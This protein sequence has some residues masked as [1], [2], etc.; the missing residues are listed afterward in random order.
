MAGWARLHL[1]PTIAPPR[2][3]QGHFRPLTHVDL[4][5]AA[6]SAH[7]LWMLTSMWE[8]FDAA[9]EWPT[10]Q[11]VGARFWREDRPEPRDV[12]LELAEDGFVSPRVQRDRLFELRDDTRASITLDGLM[13]VT[14]A[15]PDLAQFVSA[16]RYLGERAARFRP[17]TSTTLESLTIASDEIRLALPPSPT[18]ADLRR[19]AAFI[20]DY[21]P[22]LWTGFSGPDLAGQWTVTVAVERARQ[23]RQVQTI[24]DFLEVQ[25]ATR[26]RGKPLG[27]THALPSPKTSAWG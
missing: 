25:R 21:A 3:A 14:P 23:Y 6:P 22:E 1:V 20:R 11:F 16:V 8:A 12:Y 24:I 27:H 13:F 10:F 2:R 7:G 9:G 15:Q 17:A 5:D 26:V 18:G 4:P 19:Q